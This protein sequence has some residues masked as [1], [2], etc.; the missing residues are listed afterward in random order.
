MTRRQLI[1]VV[2]L[3]VA[4]VGGLIGAR[5]YDRRNARRAFA[6]LSQCLL[7][8]EGATSTNVSV[9]Y[10]RHQ[11]PLSESH[12][13]AALAWPR[14]CAPRAARL[15]DLASSPLLGSKSQEMREAFD[16]VAVLLE[17]GALPAGPEPWRPR[18]A[19]PPIP[20]GPWPVGKHLAVA[21]SL[22]ETQGLV[23]ETS[24]VEGPPAHDEVLTLDDLR[25]S[26]ITPANPDAVV[27]LTRRPLFG[28]E[29]PGFAST[30]QYC[31]AAQDTLQCVS[32]PHGPPPQIPLTGVSDTTSAGRA[33]LYATTDE[34]FW[35]RRPD[36][37]IAKSN[38]FDARTSTWV[39]GND[40]AVISSIENGQRVVAI[41][42]RSGVSLVDFDL[43]LTRLFG[44]DAPQRTSTHGPI[45]V[46]FG[47]LYFLADRRNATQLYSVRVNDDGELDQPAEL[48]TVTTPQQ[49]WQVH[50]RSCNPAPDE[51]IVIVDVADETFMSFRTPGAP[52]SALVV[53]EGAGVFRLRDCNR[54]R[55]MLDGAR[56]LECTAKGCAA[57]DAFDVNPTETAVS[58][59]RYRTTET[60]LGDKA[61]YVWGGKPGA[62]GGVFMKL[63]AGAELGIAPPQLILDDA[64]DAGQVHVAGLAA[65]LRLMGGTTEALLI[66][67]LDDGRELA[68]RIS[69]DGSVR[70]AKVEW[71]KP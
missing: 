8:P 21:W 19:P 70:P 65:D 60:L 63:A 46:S 43:E 31:W 27:G 52:P 47:H 66:V 30:G 7:G 4:G 1:V 64:V 22:A 35:A 5:A 33:P 24:T 26:L 14:T 12:E 51:H 67:L 15:R 38:A 59:P 45:Q 23:G 56:P 68:M 32:H 10:R 17:H 36:K 28:A 37:A 55:V 9:R 16:N 13:P 50:I 54:G 53:G 48:A 69:A 71:A 61:L 29:R 2:L 40:L 6:D 42:S 49:G 34:L 25:S 18:D 3:L 11:L 62:N 57:R 41:H 20:S 58:R 44:A 39:G